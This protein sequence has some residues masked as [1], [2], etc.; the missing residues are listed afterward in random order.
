[1]LDCVLNTSL[2]FE[3]SSRFYFY[4]VFHV[5]R[6]LKSVISLKYFTSFNSSDMLL[7]IQLLNHLTYQILFDRLEQ[8]LLFV[9]KNLLMSNF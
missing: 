2:L 7:N 3:D 6:F 8:N 1:M 9:M 5:I 4:K